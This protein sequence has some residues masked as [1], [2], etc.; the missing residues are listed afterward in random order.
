[1]LTIEEE[2][3][4][5]ESDDWEEVGADS[6]KAAQILEKEFQSLSQGT[7]QPTGAQL[8]ELLLLARSCRTSKLQRQMI[9]FLWP[10]LSQIMTQTWERWSSPSADDPDRHIKQ[11]A[12]STCRSGVVERWALPSP[13]DDETAAKKWA[14]ARCMRLLK[15]ERNVC[16]AD[17]KWRDSESFLEEFRRECELFVALNLT[18][19]PAKVWRRYAG[20]FAFDAIESEM[21]KIIK[22]WERNL[23]IGTGSFGSALITH[24]WVRTEFRY[25]SRRTQ[26]K[27]KAT[28]WEHA[29]AFLEMFTRLINWRLKTLL[30]SVRGKDPVR[31]PGTGN[32][33]NSNVSQQPTASS[34]E[35]AENERFQRRQMA[36]IRAAANDLP[37]L[38]VEVFMGH[39]ADLT[40]AEIARAVKVP[41]WSVPGL[42]KLVE[43]TLRTVMQTDY[44]SSNPEAQPTH[45]P[46]VQ[47]LDVKE[48]QLMDCAANFALLMT[49]LKHEAEVKAEQLVN[50]HATWCQ[51]W[52]KG[53]Q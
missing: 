24:D 9:G 44:V 49:E 33:I 52:L 41:R 28:Y 39:M 29:G 51:K 46:D 40:D 7:K 20:R 26:I 31:L 48:Q 14:E 47:T 34:V 5:D 16:N 25:L 45:Q 12:V 17:A 50:E 11:W 27:N 35:V 8:T 23:K 2:P 1:M 10:T 19:G 6:A 42:L 15:Y 22:A 32:I 13:F 18:H 37:P 43:Q 53:L 30:N 38:L 36:T 4:F 3:P 21:V